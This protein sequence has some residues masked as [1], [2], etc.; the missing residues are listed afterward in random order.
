MANNEQLNNNL[1]LPFL[2]V[3]GQYYAIA[4]FCASLFYVPVSVTMFHHAIEMLMKGYLVKTHSARLLASK[5]YGH[6]LQSLWALYKSTIRDE[7]LSRFDK[8]IND[9]NEVEKLR[10]PDNMNEDGFIVNISIREPAPLQ[11][12]NAEDIDTGMLSRLNID[13]KPQYLINVS[14]L[15]V[16]ALS[17]FEACQVNPKQIFK[18]TPVQFMSALPSEFKFDNE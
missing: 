5:A 1:S 18:D 6:N 8:S 17:I 11:F 14:N 3:G 2:V 4:R 13:N 12:S 10:Y 15:D 7:S 16:I 9:L